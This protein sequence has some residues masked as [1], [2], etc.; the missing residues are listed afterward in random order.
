MKVNMWFLVFVVVVV[1]GCGDDREVTIEPD[2]SITPP[3]DAGPPLN[4][5]CARI[6]V[7]AV[8]VADS[9]PVLVPCFDGWD[10]AITIARGP[11][12]RYN[13]DLA[14]VQQPQRYG[15]CVGAMRVLIGVTGEV[16]CDFRCA[17]PEV[18]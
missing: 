16:R 11:W 1:V 14:L 5:Q 4:A 15:G 2:G 12:T 6:L 7:G 9:G 18:R 10:L 13:S 17:V 3:V 8:F